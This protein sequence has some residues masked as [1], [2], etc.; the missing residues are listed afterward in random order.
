MPFPLVPFLFPFSSSLSLF[1]L[2]Y[3]LPPP[4]TDLLLTLNSDPSAF[5]HLLI[6]L[7]HLLLISTCFSSLL[8]PHFP[9]F[10]SLTSALLTSSD[11]HPFRFFHFYISSS[12]FYFI[13]FLISSFSCPLPYFIVLSLFILSV[14]FFPPLF[15]FLIQYFVLFCAPP[16]PTASFIFFLSRLLHFFLRPLLHNSI[17]FNILL[18]SP[19][20]FFYDSASSLLL[21]HLIF[22]FDA[23]CSSFFS[24]FFSI[25]SQM[26]PFFSLFSSYTTIS[27]PFYLS[28]PAF[29]STFRLW[30]SIHLLHFLFFLSSFT[31]LM[32]VFFPLSLLRFF[33]SALILY[34]L[35]SYFLISSLIRYP[36]YSPLASFSIFC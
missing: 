33:S 29:R 3:S 34:S 15:V 11:F 4:A 12:S 24:S 32:F 14:P 7:I 27:F 26:H 31:F 1:I 23:T 25:F 10:I 28:S 8:F 9:I 16:S 35:R 2:T 13:F 22:Y 20:L 30:K 19:S 36:S 6:G 17:L 18:S 5:T 21:P